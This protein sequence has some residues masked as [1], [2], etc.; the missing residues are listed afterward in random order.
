[1]VNKVRAQ[2]DKFEQFYPERKAL[3]DEFKFPW[4]DGLHLFEVCVPHMRAILERH[5]DL[6]VVLPLLSR[7]LRTCKGPRACFRRV[8]AATR[9][10]G[11]RGRKRSAHAS[12]AG[13]RDHSPAVPC[14]WRT[15]RSQRRPVKGSS[16]KRLRL[17]GKKAVLIE[18]PREAE[19]QE[20]EAA[21]TEAA[22]EPDPAS[23]GASQRELSQGAARRGASPFYPTTCLTA[24]WRRSPLRGDRAHLPRRTTGG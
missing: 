20:A 17:S 3:L 12:A 15:S 21:S 8:C 6:R 5:G 2:M 4:W 1:M 9:R 16:R 7:C 18:R 11:M 24:P 19:R 22:A 14:G 13:R 10:R 23:G